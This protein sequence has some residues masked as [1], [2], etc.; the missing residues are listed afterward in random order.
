MCLWGQGEQGGMLGRLSCVPHQLLVARSESDSSSQ[1]CTKHFSAVHQAK[2]VHMPQWCK[3][4]FL[5]ACFS[6]LQSDV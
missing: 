5:P 1:L 4:G 2:R 6:I 3:L